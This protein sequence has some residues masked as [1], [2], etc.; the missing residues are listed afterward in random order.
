MPSKWKCYAWL[1]TVWVDQTKRILMGAGVS[2]DIVL[3]D[4]PLL[5]HHSWTEL[6]IVFLS[7][8][9]S[10][11]SSFGLVLFAP[12]APKYQNIANTGNAYE[13]PFIN[14]DVPKTPLHQT[15]GVEISVSFFFISLFGWFSVPN[16]FST[17]FLN[18]RSVYRLS[19]LCSRRIYFFI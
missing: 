8:S 4:D 12:L 2:D 6:H 16:K 11:S 1:M 18:F 10:L 7:F 14:V 13:I 19:S 3:N 15:G 9:L 5:A 17:I